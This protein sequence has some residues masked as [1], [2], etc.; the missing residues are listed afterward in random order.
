MGGPLL[1]IGQVKIKE[2]SFCLL[3]A[4]TFSVLGGDGMELYMDSEASA[5]VPGVLG[6]GVQSSP[7]SELI[8]KASWCRRPLKTLGRLNGRE[9]GERKAGHSES[10]L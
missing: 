3:R 9:T 7:Q 4:D 5:G 1:R 2:L 6:A 8:G 10:L